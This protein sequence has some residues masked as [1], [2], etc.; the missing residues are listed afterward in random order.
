MVQIAPGSQ[1]L[2]IITG[3]TDF[4]ADDNFNYTFTNTANGA[5]AVAFDRLFD[6][7]SAGLCLPDAASPGES[8]ADSLIS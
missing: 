8:I 7:Y 1:Y 2:A 6:M 3:S 4:N 5:F